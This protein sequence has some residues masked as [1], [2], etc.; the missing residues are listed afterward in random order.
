MLINILCKIMFYIIS[1]ICSSDD[2]VSKLKVSIFY[3]YQ[4][5]HEERE[6]QERIDV[7]N[8]VCKI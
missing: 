5:D 6:V 1:S 2:Q 4:K 7:D 3:I 8:T